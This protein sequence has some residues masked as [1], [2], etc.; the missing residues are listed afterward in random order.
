MVQLHMEN[1]L[2]PSNDDL[3]KKAITSSS[4]QSD[5]MKRTKSNSSSVCSSRHSAAKSTTQS[6]GHCIRGRKVA[7]AV[8]A[9]FRV[10]K[11]QSSK[12]PVTMRS[13]MTKY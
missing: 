9:T 10:K 7:K 13:P 5:K 12:E 4:W 8:K 11:R 6:K 1:E 3:A 2:L